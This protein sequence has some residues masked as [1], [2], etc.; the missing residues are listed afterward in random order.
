M[1]TFRQETGFSMIE[2]VIAMFLVAVT[3]LS[4]APLVG[5]AAEVGNTAGEVTGI[6]ALA[7]EKIEELTNETYLELVPGGDVDANV[8]GYFDTPDFDNDGDTDFTRR[9]AITDLGTAMLVQVRVISR[10][11]VVGQVK[12]TLLTALVPRL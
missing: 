10:D 3:L 12:E 4:I 2:A 8:A 7:D 9:W 1:G 6:T 5:I 11:I